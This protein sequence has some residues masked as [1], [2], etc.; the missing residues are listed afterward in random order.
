MVERLIRTLKE[1][2]VHRHR[3]E[4]LQHASRVIRDWIRSYNTRRPGYS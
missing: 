1:Q 3:F 4:A 2:C